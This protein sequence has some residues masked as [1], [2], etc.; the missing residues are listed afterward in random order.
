MCKHAGGTGSLHV[1]RPS[2]PG[3][4]HLRAA[5]PKGTQMPWQWPAVWVH[6]RKAPGHQILSRSWATCAVTSGLGMWGAWDPDRAACRE[7]QGSGDGRRPCRWSLVL[8][9][10]ALCLPAQALVLPE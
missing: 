1:P 3:D 8:H 2:S 10:R 9:D 4:G 6:P 7:L 5:G